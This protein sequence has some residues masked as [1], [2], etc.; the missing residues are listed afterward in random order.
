MG[1]ERAARSRRTRTIG[2]S[3]P[4]CPEKVLPPQARRFLAVALSIVSV[5]APAAAED[6]KEPA[7]AAAQNTHDL[8]QM[9]LED[10][11][12]VPTV[13]ASGGNVVQVGMA[14]GNVKV[15]TRQD[16]DNNGW[17]TLADVLGSI[18]GFYVTSDGSL[19]SIGVR[20]VTGGL[21]A[22][23]RLVK[24]MING[25]P[26]NFR[27]ELRSFL[28]P[29][30]IPIEL[31]ERIEVVKGPLSA[32]YGANAFIGTVNVITRDPSVGMAVTVSGAGF[33]QN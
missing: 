26:V 17:R 10:L 33:V 21:Q 20:G 27:P 19:T 1:G 25:T 30:F 22:G 18:P 5:S 3:S 8:A 28:G 13:T 7:P 2:S 9:S 6:T 12:S 24:I 31:V 16:I 15:I 29:E 11:L 32:L 4:S 23:T 14:S